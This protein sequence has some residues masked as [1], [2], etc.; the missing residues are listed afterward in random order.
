MNSLAKLLSVILMAA[1][2]LNGGGANSCELVFE[3]DV[4]D[5]R[6]VTEQQMK[7]AKAV[8]RARL[9][10]MAMPEADVSYE[11][12][13]IVVKIPDGADT[14]N[15]I[16]TL[17][18]MGQLTFRNAAGEILMEGNGAN[19]KA[20]E[21]CYGPASHYGNNEYYISIKFTPEGRKIFKEATEAVFEQRF[22]GQN[23][24]AI[25]L[26]DELISMPMVAEVIDSDSCI[27]TGDFT[28]EAAKELAGIIS[29]GSLPFKLKFVE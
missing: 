17:C 15:V 3:P 13:K 1:S 11:N 7:A 27:I 9:D 29:A 16:N 2:A 24:I 28:E 14:E 23:Y 8:V 25:Y 21:Y 20:A 22:E 12:T 26:D 19:I 4:Q 18:E 10:A 6:T 5:E